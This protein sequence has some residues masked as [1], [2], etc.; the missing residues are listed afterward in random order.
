M[1][2]SPHDDQKQRE[3]EEGGASGRQLPEIQDEGEPPNRQNRRERINGRLDP[4]PRSHQIKGI[5]G[6]LKSFQT[7]QLIIISLTI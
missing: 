4:L 6:Q 1:Q 5:Q 3:K 2:F 7:G